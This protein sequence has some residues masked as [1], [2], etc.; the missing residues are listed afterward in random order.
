MLGSNPGLAVRRSNHSARSHP[1]DAIGYL[2]FI[3]RLHYSGSGPA[4]GSDQDQDQDQMLPYTVD[5]NQVNVGTN[6]YYEKK[7]FCLQYCDF[8]RLMYMYLLY[9]E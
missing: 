9:C 8:S 3:R 4:S 1:I 7:T 5:K 6:H 2:Q